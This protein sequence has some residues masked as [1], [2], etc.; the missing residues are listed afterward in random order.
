VETTDGKW[1]QMRILPYR[2]SE[3]R[4]DGVVATF[5]DITKIKQFELSIEDARN[6]AE[7]IIETVREPL[8]VL[9]ANLRIVSANRSFYATFHTTPEDSNKKF[10]S[11]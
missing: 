5:S 7:N 8:V 3:N 2:T 4:I 9:D 6:Y 1:F 11:P 10:F